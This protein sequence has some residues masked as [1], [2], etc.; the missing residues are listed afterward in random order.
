M[1]IAKKI[2]II[3]ISTLAL[4]NFQISTDYYDVIKKEE[5][6]IVRKFN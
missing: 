3:I 6:A 5:I 2:I 1:N 4:Y